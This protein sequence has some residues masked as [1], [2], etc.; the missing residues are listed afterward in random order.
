M[1]T[2]RIIENTRSNETERFDSVIENFELGCSYS[3]IQKNKTKEFDILMK[4]EY[5]NVDDTNIDSIIFGEN[6]KKFFI[7]A[8]SPLKEYTYFIMSD[9]GNT[10]ERL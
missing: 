10:L 4:E 1:Y 2:L 6:G 5:P 3:R 7:E 9:N 8:F